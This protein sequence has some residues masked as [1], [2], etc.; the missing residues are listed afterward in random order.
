MPS[1]RSVPWTGRPIW[2]ACGR[3]AP[4]S[5]PSS[6]GQRAGRPEGE[7]AFVA[8]AVPATAK[9]QIAPHRTRKQGGQQVGGGGGRQMRGERAFAL[10]AVGQ[11]TEVGEAGAFPGL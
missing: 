2:N 6:P 9:H 5:G 1:R 11:G 7:V 4:T 10:K 3:P 8:G